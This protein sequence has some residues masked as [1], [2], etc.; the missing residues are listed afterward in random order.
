[1][2]P[3]ISPSLNQKICFSLPLPPSKNRRTV[4]KGVYVKR[5]GKFINVPVLSQDVIAYRIYVNNFLAEYKN[6]FKKD[7]K[8][9]LNC[10]W[11][12]PRKNCDVH[13]YHA[14]LCDSIAVPL[15]LDDKMFLV[16]DM[17]FNVDPK[18]PHVWVEMFYL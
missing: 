13:N 10:F 9:V 1:M 2:N 17:D 18:N 11:A 12:K 7:R 15:N 6:H 8:I 16:R 4:R 3:S 5:I 14:E